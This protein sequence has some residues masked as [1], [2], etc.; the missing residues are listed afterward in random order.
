MMSSPALYLERLLSSAATGE[1]AR[2]WM[3]AAAMGCGSDWDW[4]WPLTSISRKTR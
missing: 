4:L 2:C 3:R 1:L